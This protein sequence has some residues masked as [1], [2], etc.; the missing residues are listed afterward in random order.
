MEFAQDFRVP[1]EENRIGYGGFWLEKRE[2]LVR[3]FPGDQ[4]RS[5]NEILN[6]FDE[7]LL[8]IST[9]A[10]GQEGHGQDKGENFFCTF[11][12]VHDPGPVP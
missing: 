8:G 11:E 6:G 12:A 2:S 5:G 7:T 10:K 3:M 4:D 1:K 9:H